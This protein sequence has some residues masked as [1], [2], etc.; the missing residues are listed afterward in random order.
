MTLSAPAPLLSGRILVL[1]KVESTYNVDAVPTPGSNALLVNDADLTVDPNVLERDFARSSLSP[2]AVS[3]GRKLVNLTFSHELKSSGTVG[4]PGA[5]GPL[6]RG[7]GFSQT[8][9]AN[10]A[11]ATVGTPVAGSANAGPSVSW[12]KGAASDK[13]GRYRITVTKG[14]ASATAELRVSGT[15]ASGEE[16]ILPNETFAAEVTTTAGGSGTMTLAQGLTAA[17]DFS[18]ITYTVGGS[19]TADDVLVA[20]IGG[21]KYRYTVTG[22]EA[23]A[24]AVATAFAAVIDADARLAASAASSVITVTFSGA[25]DTVVVTSGTTAITLGE[26]GAEITPT[27]TGNL[28]LGDYWDVLVL[29]PGVHYTP[30]SE[31]FESLTVYMYF[32]GILH[33]VTGCMGSVVFS[34]E[35]GNFG[36]AQFSFT[37]Q[38]LPVIDSPI[39]S[40][41]VYEQTIPRQVELA[42][43][44][45]G[46]V[47]DFCAQS[48]S[49]DM[50]NNVVPR[51]CMNN[52]DGFN[53]VRITARSPQGTINPEATRESHFPFW[54]YLSDSTQFSFHVKVGIEAGNI[55]RILSDSVQISNIT[56]GDR[57]E[58]RTYELSLRFSQY[59]GDGDDEIRVVFA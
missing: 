2:L 52:T 7:C 10:T 46:A 3:L 9:V 55:V 45:L 30:V 51:D 44:N 43:L 31:D 41:T 50:Q 16:S 17:N 24:D 59:S 57:N 19:V 15:P 53:G 54:E 22:L 8:T 29:E 39:P 27:W 47:D 33:R 11:N 36:L 48:F 5:I 26:S 13:T 1:A 23:D 20:T 49:I 58:L 34:G 21:K 14:G 40:G 56:Y 37:G 32:D 25:A 38:Y 12:A 18:S 6:L 28:S 4:T 35:A 42:E